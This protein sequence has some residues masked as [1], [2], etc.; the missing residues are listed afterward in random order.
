MYDFEYNHSDQ[1]ITL[2]SYKANRK[3]AA[4]GKTASDKVSTKNAA[5]SDYCKK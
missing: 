3:K 5:S 1:L 4:T 2:H